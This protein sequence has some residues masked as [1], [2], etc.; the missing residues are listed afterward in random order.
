MLDQPDKTPGQADNSNRKIVAWHSAEV[1]E[2]VPG[3]LT[4]VNVFAN[5]SSACVCELAA[6]SSIV[7]YSS[8]APV[9][10]R[11]DP[12]DHVFAVVGGSGAVRISSLDRNGK[13]HMVEMFGLGDLF[14]EVEV[15]DGGHRT[16][17]A[18]A[19][20]ART[21][22]RRHA[23]YLQQLRVDETGTSLLVSF[24]IHL[25]AHA[26][27]PVR[28]VRCAGD[29]RTALRTAGHQAAFGTATGRALSG[30]GKSRLLEELQTRAGADGFV[31]AAGDADVIE[32]TVPF[33]A[34]RGVV[35]ALLGLDP[36]RPWSGQ[37]RAAVAAVDMLVPGAA[38]RAALFNAVLPL[39]IAETPSTATLVPAERLAALRAL[40]IALLR[41]CCLLPSTT[42]TGQTLKAGRSPRPSSP[43]SPVLPW[44]CACSRWPKTAHRQR[45]LRP[46][47]RACCL[48]RLRRRRRTRWRGRGSERA[49]SGQRSPHFCAGKRVATRSFALSLPRRSRTML[50]SRWSMAR[51]DWSRRRRRVRSHS[52]TRCS[53]P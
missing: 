41:R 47:H 29:L 15:L 19:E 23:G 14:G 38:D 27:D 22:V 40:L 53:R 28:T 9:F 13:A 1:G 24:G 16:A 39:G 3:F 10:E 2:L 25:M 6:G 32:A 46:A 8:E 18:V 48:A 21:T 43:Q 5:L 45:S 44:C 49:S 20:V 51:L 36:A 42:P 17:D 37:G 4:R 50:S 26:E 11:G 31:L 34:W 35:A 52:R 30:I 33:R 12:A 7:T